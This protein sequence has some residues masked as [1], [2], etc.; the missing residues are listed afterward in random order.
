VV[1][2]VKKGPGVIATIKEVT[3]RASGATKEEAITELKKL[4]PDKEP[5]GWEESLP[6]KCPEFQTRTKQPLLKKS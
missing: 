2:A 5:E 6:Y 1:K 3:G 4:F